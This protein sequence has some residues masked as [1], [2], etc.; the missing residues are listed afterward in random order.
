MRDWQSGLENRYFQVNLLK[1]AETTTGYQKYKVW[2]SSVFK[3]TIQYFSESQTVINVY[4]LH[5]V[6]VDKFITIMLLQM[7][8]STGYR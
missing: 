5:V 3:N 6:G 2:V 7:H 1:R 8:Y 4:L